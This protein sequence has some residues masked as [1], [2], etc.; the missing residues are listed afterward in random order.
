MNCS[1]AAVEPG[2]AGD[3]VAGRRSACAGMSPARGPG[4]GLGAGAAVEAVD[5][6]AEDLGQSSGPVADGRP[7]AE[8]DADHVEHPRPPACEPLVEPFQGVFEV[9]P[10]RA[11]AGTSNRPSTS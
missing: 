2:D 8:P 10:R 7:L 3:E 11:N 4:R 1:P 5:P 9:G 6:A